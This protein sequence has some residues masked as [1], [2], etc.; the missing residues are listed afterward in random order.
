MKEIPGFV[1]RQKKVALAG[2]YIMRMN[3]ACNQDVVVVVVMGCLAVV[4]GKGH[5]G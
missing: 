3:N 2:T 1:T 5:A 4:N